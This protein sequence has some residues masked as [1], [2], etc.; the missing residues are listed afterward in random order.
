[1][2]KPHPAELKELLKNLY[3]MRRIYIIGWELMIFLGLV[4]LGEE[5]VFTQLINEYESNVADFEELIN[6]YKDI[7]IKKLPSINGKWKI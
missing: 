4:V 6:Y 1:M 7:D 2:V 3:P 5:G